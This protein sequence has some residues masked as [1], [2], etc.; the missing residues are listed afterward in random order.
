[1]LLQGDNNTEALI[2]KMAV[3]RI[4]DISEEKSIEWKEMQFRKAA[5]MKL[6]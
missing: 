4:V 6:Y 1:M 3:S 2:I 5:G